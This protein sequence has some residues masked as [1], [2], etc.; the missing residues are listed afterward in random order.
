MKDLVAK[1]NIS[2]Y[3]HIESRATHTDEIWNDRGNPVYGPVR[4]L[5]AD[6]GISCEGKTAE[7]LKKSDYNDYDYIIG[8]DSENMRMMK[9]LFGKDGK[10]SLLMDY[11]D[12]PGSVADPWYTRDFEA[13][14][15]DVVEGCDAFLR[16]VMPRRLPDVVPYV[17]AFSKKSVNDLSESA[18]DMLYEDC[19]PKVYR[20]SNVQN[21][22]TT[23]DKTQNDDSII[24]AF[25]T[26]L[27]GVSEGCYE[28]M[29]LGFKLGDDRDKVTE[30]YKR[31]GSRLGINPD[32]I[33]CPYQVHGTNIRVVK[34]PEDVDD[35]TS[36]G[37]SNSTG[38]DNH[39]KYL[40][41]ILTKN[42]ISRDITTLTDA[43]G[44]DAEITNI[45]GVSLIAYGAD[46]VPILFYDSIRKCIG[47][48]HAG[49]RGTVDCIAAR[50]VEKLTEV[51]G[52]D[53]ADVRVS[54]GPSAGPDFYEVDEGVITVVNRCIDNLRDGV[55]TNQNTDYT[56]NDSGVNEK[57]HRD[58]IQNH[59]KTPIYTTSENSGHYLLNLWEL[60]KQILI[61]AGVRPK[62]IQISGLC[63]IEHHGIFF[64]HRVSGVRRGLNAGIICM[65]D[66]YRQ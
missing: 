10:L 3:F 36:Y 20:T 29:N 24:A 34:Y 2:E 32:M 43:D 51:F 62:H 5:L 12:R 42:G 23:Y 41:D 60:N 35:T 26:R 4:M 37:K 7:L 19:L 18:Y 31:L 50:V 45:P 30:N 39:N 65:L 63:T 17:E 9:R 25:T 61:A 59:S 6:K 58:Y 53:P 49:W 47:T 16:Y 48:A 28:S 8:M 40:S 44:I 46:C 14:Y 15:R 21:T 13:T 56:S 11:T 52:S 22:D 66:S 55:N 54:I 1:L 64:S 27:G 33:C 38:K 57:P